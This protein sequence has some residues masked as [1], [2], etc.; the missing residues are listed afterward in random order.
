MNI[1]K[2]IAFASIKKNIKRTVVTVIAVILST[3]LIVGTAGLA[4]SAHR[5]LIDGAKKNVGDFHL[6]FF[7]VEKE[8]LKYASENQNVASY[9]YSKDLGYAAFQGIRNP[10]KP[11]IFVRALDETAKHGGFGID[12]L[13]GRLPENETELL[14]P[15]HLKSNGG[16]TLNVGD[17]VSL[18]LGKRIGETGDVLTQ[19]YSFEEDGAETLADTVSR[20]YT[21]VG[22]MAR[23]DLE[24]ERY[25]APG[26]TAYTCLTDTQE[27]GRYNIS[28]TFTRVRNYGTVLKQIE[29]NLSEGVYVN[30][31]TDLLNY[32]GAVGYN[33]LKFLYS[34]VAIILSIIIL[35]SVFVIRNSF[36]IS[37]SEKNR[38]Y[39]ILSSVGATSKQIKSSV[40]YEGFLYG[41]IGIPLGI[42]SGIFAVVVLLKVVNLLIG[43][44]INGMELKFYIHP[45]VLLCAALLAAVTIYL[46]GRIPA[47]IAAKTSPIVAIRGNREVNVRSKELKV[48]RFTQKIFGIG[49]VLA[50]KNLRRSRKK[51]R[52]TVVSLVLSL[53][54]FI[55]LYS[56]TS[57]AKRGVSSQV[58]DY[59]YNII[60][61]IPDLVL[62]DG[63][64][65][66]FEALAKRLELREYSYYF[67]NYAEIDLE[68]YG[69]A[70]AKKE[71]Q[72][73]L[74]IALSME[75]GEDRLSDAELIEIYKTMSVNFYELN[76]DYFNLY[77][78]RLG[79]PVDAAAILFD[80]NG[81]VTARAGD[82]VRF[83][84]TNDETGETIEKDITIDKITD[85][86]PMGLENFS[87]T[88]C[89]LIFPEGFISNGLGIYLYPSRSMFV[90]A[91]DP[92][93][94]EAQIFDLRAA[95]PE[96]AG[97]A[98][99]NVAKEGDGMRRIILVAE[100][101]LYGFISVITLIGVTN[102]FNTISTNML[103]RSKEFAMLRSVGMTKKEFHRMIRLESLLYGLRALLFGIP[104]GIAGAVLIY[105][106]FEDT[107]GMSFSFPL[108][109]ILW[110]A[111][112]VF[113]IVGLTM[114]YSLKK[115]N[116]QNIIETIRRDNI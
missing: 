94:L 115:I 64:K 41:V 7:N 74:Q 48:S 93:A 19:N 44:L 90:K 47:A 50:V 70:Y 43:D 21:V 55:S 107:F 73:D 52:T 33:F 109:P 54:V 32:Q 104:L 18:S 105:F 112:G 87:T 20:T 91:D 8:E 59:K 85:E 77:R 106:P 76:A 80:P 78:Q 28:V 98:V 36:A 10:D 67:Y 103:L 16:I 102:I 89:C 66:Y 79:A 22:I 4:L 26:Y 45:L 61:G 111:L 6:T 114:L 5:S 17:R 2:K 35:T 46:S 100:I 110:G 23:P 30:E 69:S 1:G 37:V 53:S 75:A 56:F 99:H 96:F 82:T 60:I 63:I 42:L 116:G 86:K 34:I 71:A 12:L 113:V 14:L 58:K 84:F 9:F 65:P 101:F 40:L 62:G 27:T 57:L 13:E 15:A 92:D 108:V 97:T 39:G 11:Y 31:N 38:Q 81:N 83:T 88:A 3:A 49:G 24:L 68:T 25:D 29:S 72:E 51:Y 95:T